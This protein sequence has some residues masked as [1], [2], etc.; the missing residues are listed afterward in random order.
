M[1]ARE[2]LSGGSG[3]GLRPHPPGI[4]VQSNATSWAGARG[5]MQ[6]MPGTAS[7]VARDRRLRS[8]NRHHLYDPDVNLELGQSYIEIL[9]NEE[10]IGSDLFHLAAAWNGG[11]GNLSKWQRRG[12]GAD[13]R[14]SS[15][16]ASVGGDPQFHRAGAD[17]PM[18]LSRPIGPAQSVVGRLGV[19][20]PA[21]LRAARR[22]HPQRGATW[23]R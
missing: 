19:G 10:H 14:C 20:R 2:R 4:P 8:S 11:P 16:R 3:A 17:Q 12:N 9:L 15:S 1:G 18:D 7:F 23:P 13:D 22:A 5:L 21:D 6:L